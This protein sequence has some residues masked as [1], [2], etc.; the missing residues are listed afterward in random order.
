MY[1]SFAACS[2]IQTNSRPRTMRDPQHEALLTLRL[3]CQFQGNLKKQEV[4]G[5]LLRNLVSHR[6]H[7]CCTTSGGLPCV[8]SLTVLIEK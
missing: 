8:A 3:N 1:I 2:V 4:A 7:R 5:G 6:S